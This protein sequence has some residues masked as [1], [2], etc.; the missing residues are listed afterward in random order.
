MKIV[1]PTSEITSQVISTSTITTTYAK[2][3]DNKILTTCSNKELFIDNNNVEI[4]QDT[5]NLCIETSSHIVD[6]NISSKPSSSNKL[7]Y[8][9]N[10][11]SENLTL[12]EIP[13]LN[14]I[15]M[16]SIIINN[17]TAISQSSIFSATVNKNIIAKKKIK[18]VEL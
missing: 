7:I 16:Q 17:E 2:E 1:Y 8:L 13:V 6:N 15:P 14:K 10:N 4:I 5:Q 11:T 18:K 12:N 3:N 9:D